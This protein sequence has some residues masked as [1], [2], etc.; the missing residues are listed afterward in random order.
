M[1]YC[2]FYKLSSY[3]CSMFGGA[4]GVHLTTFKTCTVYS[5]IIGFK[6]DRVGGEKRHAF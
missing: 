6:R 2:P 5:A 1:K 3:L 4:A